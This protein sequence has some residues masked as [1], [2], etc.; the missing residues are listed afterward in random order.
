LP[1]CVLVEEHRAQDRDLGVHVVRG[2]VR[3]HRRTVLPLA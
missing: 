1:V 2:D 3:V